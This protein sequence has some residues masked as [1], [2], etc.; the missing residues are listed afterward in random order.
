LLLPSITIESL[1]ILKSR[2]TA[3]SHCLSQG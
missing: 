3:Q 1:T 2:V